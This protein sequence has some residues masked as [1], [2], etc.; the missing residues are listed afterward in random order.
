[1]HSKSELSKDG[2]WSPV[3]ETWVVCVYLMGV[4]KGGGEKLQGSGGSQTSQGLN[5][6]YSLKPQ[7][8]YHACHAIPYHAI[9]Y[10]NIPYHAIPN[11]PY[12]TYHTIQY[13][14]IINTNYFYYSLQP[15][16]T[17]TT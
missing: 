12:H 10:H 7:T 5:S 16:N 3:F 15:E 11:M 1:M 8:A 17:L 9:P 13:H 4:K 14:I 6:Y 2:L